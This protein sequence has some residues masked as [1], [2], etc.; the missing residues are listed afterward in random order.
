MWKSGWGRRV[1][2]VLIGFK[3]DGLVY[4]PKGTILMDGSNQTV[5]GRV[6][7]KRVTIDGSNCTIVSG[8]GDLDSLP[9]SS[10]RLIE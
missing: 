9:L 6:I 4:A 8:S 5:N 7:G 10:V 2:N 1:R 3:L